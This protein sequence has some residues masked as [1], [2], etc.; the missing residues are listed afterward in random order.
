MFDIFNIDIYLGQ[1]LISN[2]MN[3]NQLVFFL[4]GIESD[5]STKLINK[6]FDNKLFNLYADLNYTIIKRIIINNDTIRL[7]RFNNIIDEFSFMYEIIENSL[8][9]TTNEK[10]IHTLLKKHTSNLENINYYFITDLLDENKYFLSIFTSY[11]LA[12]FEHNYNIYSKNVLSFNNLVDKLIGN[13]SNYKI[14]SI[15]LDKFKNI[16]SIRITETKYFLF[17]KLYLKNNLNKL[18]DNI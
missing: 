6:M 9:Y 7:G 14:I 3:R 1:D 16:D 17:N 8:K 2:D 5:R 10:A 12:N 4:I 18:L 13:Q 15:L 11:F